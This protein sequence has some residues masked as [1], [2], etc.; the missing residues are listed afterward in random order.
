MI[1]VSDLNKKM[2]S[3]SKTAFMIFL[4][5]LSLLVLLLYLFFGRAA[6]SADNKLSDMIKYSN[7]YHASFLN[8]TNMLYLYVDSS[9]VDYYS[10]YMKENVA[11][12]DMNNAKNMLAAIGLE[13][14]EKEIL[15]QIDSAWEK[16]IAPAE[17]NALN[18]MIQEAKQ[19]QAREFISSNE[20]TS[21]VKYISDS[22]K[23]LRDAVITRLSD[24]KKT[25]ELWESIFQVI[26]IFIVI[27]IIAVSYACRNRI[28]RL[29]IM[30]ENERESQKEI[31]INN[32]V[33]KR[34]EMR[35]SR[36]RR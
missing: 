33:L 34:R 8:R 27:G 12:G 4:C 16:Y 22:Q 1:L 20:Y 15:N 3:F 32:D 19:K 7:Q 28:K 5:L 17:Q 24:E 9:N 23:T 18:K 6:M 13:D 2:V 30:V 26:L 36:K 31:K 35:N 11:T 25:Y 21:C 29:G 10:E 14:S